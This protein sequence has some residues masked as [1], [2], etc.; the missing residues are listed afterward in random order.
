MA[1]ENPSPTDETAA[2]EPAPKPPQRTPNFSDY[3]RVFKYA[4]K[5]DFCGY[6]VAS[7]ASLGA[8]VTMPLMNVVFGQL[9]GEFTDYFRGTTAISR[10]DFDRIL[11]RQALL[12]M[13][14]FLLRWTLSS[15]N[16]FCFRMIGIRLSSAVLGHYLRALF[17]QSVHVVDSMPPGAPATAITVTST[18]LQIGISERLGTLLEFNA[19]LW[20]AL[21][22]A[23]TW[24]WDLTL[25][26]SSLVVYMMVVLALLL[27]LIVKGQAATG[28]ADAEGTAIA[29][30]ALGG[31]RLVMA[32]GAQG[33]TISRYQRWVLEAKKSGQKTAPIA[34]LQFGLVFFGVF[35]AYGL[36]FWYGAQRYMAGA[37]TNV[38]TIIVVLMSVML[39]LVSI[40]RV[41]TPLMA[42][43]K[44]MLAA[45]EL[46]T[47]IDAPLPTSGSL[48]P[49]ISGEDLFFRDVMFEYPS[50]PGVQVLDGLNVRIRSGQNT[51]VVGPSGSGKSTIVALLARWY[52]LKDQPMVPEV[53][54]QP[55]EK[56]GGDQPDN[57]SQPPARPKLSGSITVGDHNLEDL[58][59]HWWRARIG[60]VQQEPF[61]FNDT[62]FNNVANGLIG[63]QWQDDSEARKRELVEEACRE[64]YA[65]EFIRRL[66]DGYDTQVGDGGA[67]L[68]GGQKQRLAIARSII[69]KPQ[70]IIL[71]EATS[72]IDAKSEKIV[73]AALDRATQN[74]TTI[75]IAHRLSTIKKADHIIVMRNGQAV[76]QGTH[77]SLLEDAGGVYSA[78]VRA[79]LLQLSRADETLSKEANFE[80]T[81]K[82]VVDSDTE[83]AFDDH[84]HAV[85]PYTPT[86]DNAGDQSR[87]EPANSPRGI[88][89]SFGKLLYEQ[90]AQWVSYLGIVLSAM[91]VAAATPLQA[92]LFAQVLGVF[93]VTDDTA[94]DRGSDFWGLMWLALAGGVLVSYFC[95][96]WFGLHVQYAVSA[97]YKTQYLTDMLH[98]QV[99][100][101]DEDGN[102]HGA[103]T[104]R[105]TGDAKQLEELLG[106]NLA[107]LLSGVF[108][109]VGCVAIA[110]VFGW[111]LALIAAFVTMPVMLF[112]GYW[113]F[114]HEI[115]FNQMSSE[116]FT[117]S[118][119][120]ATEAIGAIRTVS[121]LT[122]EAT[123]NDR[124]QKL[125]DGHV[126][127]ALRKACSMCVMFGFADSA[128]LGC[129]ALVF[130]Y[131]GGMLARGEYT[132]QAFLVCFMAII[133]G[134]EAASQSLS[135]AP[136]AAQAV[137]AANRI[138]DI[139][140]SA[141][142][143]RQR[144][145]HS[146]GVPKADSGIG[147]ELR[148]VYFKYPTRDVSV[149]EGLSL[150]I[151]K[152][153]YVAFVGASGSGK[154]TIIS[155]LERFYDLGPGQGAIL[156]N[157]TNINNLDAYSYRKTLSLVAQE[158]IMFRGTIRENILFGV[159]D[160]SSVSDA[161]VEE[162]CRDAFIHDFIVSLPEGY[163]TEVG[164]KGVSMS[165]G[166]KQRV[167][168]ARA[169]IRDPKIL[170][171]D[172][173]TS[174]LD[175]ESEKVVQAALE[176]A[177]NGR[178]MIAVAHRLSTIQNADAIFVLDNGRVVETGTHDDLLKRQG[179]YWEMCQSQ[180]LDQ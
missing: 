51:A 1:A 88:I 46:F 15:V 144:T 28:R 134:A 151:D 118:S 150:S 90:R 52:S 43:S 114:R 157:G 119:K 108:S 163:N 11:T 37:L 177:R 32:C 61:L 135:A 86:S 93:L 167:A 54:A 111:K 48:K 74:R 42:V 133:Q 59:V 8:G 55:N 142:I 33:R 41:A 19:T 107:F 71:D 57:E 89:G 162:V 7:A 68:S 137:A 27:P 124:Y 30:E 146:E 70:I 24:S 153:Q 73:Q 62:I 77:Q 174:A 56:M 158:P 81:L 131:G 58:D 85:S 36:S 154:S 40:E 105:V 4:T 10:D 169:L 67:K 127:A 45:C 47:L 159:E 3:L 122:M 104:S 121:A 126:K 49:D 69:K 50:R 26:T 112:S 103:L 132:L 13:A 180:A 138:L 9:V 14:L 79:Q 102:A 117:E 94:L 99:A 63:T 25:V 113:K 106:M 66:P 148:D 60:L 34:G 98:Q 101:F 16:K 64:A 165:G 139:R 147:I 29:S 168:I 145:G 44:A 72:A 80:A 91:A 5:W 123:I 161:R 92:W 173:A 6:V 82:E 84:N 83:K 110:L 87:G 152:G 120:F 116:V 149:F 130:W 141:N 100:F 166:Q 179:I 136:N 140:K 129:Q 96:G 178:T 53:V 65:H 176:S 23:F 172:E 2:T 171:L 35:G 170:L 125:L 95:E 97:V 109:V 75:T 175:S 76:E 160:P 22:I 115:H 143:D 78:L 20:S 18:T 39:I 155:L 21:I 12:I 38:G 156:C 17:A 128:S 31:I 164:L